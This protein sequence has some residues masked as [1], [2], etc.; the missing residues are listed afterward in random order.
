MAAQV[1]YSDEALCQ[2]VRRH[3]VLYD[4]GHPHYFRKP[5][6]I[7]AWQKI[8]SMFE[9]LDGVPVEGRYGLR[10]TVLGLHFSTPKA[11]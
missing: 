10:L 9:P 2:F 6:K 5:L 7:I 11:W 3:P 4:Y 8:A 1:P